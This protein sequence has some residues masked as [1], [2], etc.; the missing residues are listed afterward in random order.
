MWLPKVLYEAIP[1]YYL[2]VGAAALGAAFYLESWYWAEI[3]AGFGLVALVM[4]L[5]ILLRRKGYRASRS[6]LDFDSSG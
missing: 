5:V 1:F 2:G 3:S 6:R 4:G